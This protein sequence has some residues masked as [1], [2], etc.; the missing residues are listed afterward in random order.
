MNSQWRSSVSKESLA[1]TGTREKPRIPQHR[2]EAGGWHSMRRGSG[3]QTFRVLW[4]VTRMLTCILGG[5]VN[6]SNILENVLR[7]EG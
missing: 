4:D 1:G 3:N 5:K 6:D 7:G 2:E